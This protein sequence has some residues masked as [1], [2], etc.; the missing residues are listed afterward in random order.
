V[1]Q[2]TSSPFEVI[3]SIPTP[4]T[5]VTSPVGGETFFGGDPISIRWTSTDPKGDVAILLKRGDETVTNFGLVPMVAGGLDVSLC[6]LTGGASDFAIRLF[7]G[8]CGFSSSSISEPFSI[9]PSRTQPSLEVISPTVGATLVAGETHTILW[10]VTNPFGDV[11]LTLLDGSLTAESLGAAAMSDGAFVWASCPGLIDS[12]EYSIRFTTECGLS[13]ESEL[14]S[15]VGSQ[16]APAVIW[17]RPMFG[18]TFR[19]GDTETI[20]WGATNPTG[21][22]R[23]LLAPESWFTEELGIVAMSDE[24][25]EWSIAPEFA[26]L[27]TYRLLAATVNCGRGVEVSPPFT[28]VAQDAGD[29]DLDR[30]VDGDDYLLL[31][32]CIDG[33][34]FLVGEG[35]FRADLND[36]RLVDLRD[37]MLAFRFFTGS[38]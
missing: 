32:Q 4:G 25:F 9:T 35:C 33:P 6:D 5:T 22:I 26:T 27:G 16:P 2:A 31:Q 19:A 18:E 29:I 15:L 8:N 3:G 23:I 36:D 14:F 21:D 11:F 1:V 10:N 13:W 7:W 28:I 34:G 38:Q 20:T 37:V 12:D 30:D 17:K 24:Q